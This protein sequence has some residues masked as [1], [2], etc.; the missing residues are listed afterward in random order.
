VLVLFLV[1][2][3]KQLKEGRKGYLG[4]QFEGTASSDQE[5]MAEGT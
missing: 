5:G 4:L 1:A 3:T 2:A